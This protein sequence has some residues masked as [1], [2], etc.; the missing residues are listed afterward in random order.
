MITVDDKKMEWKNDMS[1][2]DLLNQLPHTN[3]CAAVR[4]NGKLVSSP[5]FET[6]KIPDN[7]VIYLLPLIAGG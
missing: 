6:T 3:F 5:F 4:L 2:R 1:V 7:A